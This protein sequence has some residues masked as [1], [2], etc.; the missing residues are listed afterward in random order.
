MAF[1]FDGKFNFQG[2]MRYRF[3]FRSFSF[4]GAD[5]TNEF[6]M[7]L[8]CDINICLRDN[9]KMCVA[10]GQIDD[11]FTADCNDGYECFGVFC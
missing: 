6:D 9:K 2:K 11:V 5:N 3:R 4:I 10:A 7:H 1:C 8:V